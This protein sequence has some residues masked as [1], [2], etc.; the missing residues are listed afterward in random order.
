MWFAIVFWYPVVGTSQAEL[1]VAWGDRARDNLE[2]ALRMR[3]CEIRVLHVP[4][5]SAAEEF[6]QAVQSGRIR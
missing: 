1:C 2:A 6:Q 5:I 4:A 3:G